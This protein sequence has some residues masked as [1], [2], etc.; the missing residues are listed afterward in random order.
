M[1]SGMSR[2]GSLVFV[3]LAGCT[4]CSK[5]T[6]S[7]PEGS[8]PA[9]NKPDDSAFKDSAKPTEMKDQKFEERLR[10]HS[11]EGT[12]TVDAPADAKAGSETTATITVKPKTGYHVNTEYPIKLALDPPANVTLA[13]KELNAGGRTKDKGDAEALD[14]Q[15]L[16]LAVKLT[17]AQA[18]SYTINGSFKFAVCDKDQCLQKKEPITITVAAK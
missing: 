8:K 14:E 11:E 7:N 16:V 17:A 15:Q 18:G 4:G 12:L 1:F 3:L 6:A 10:L 13:K 5:S 9:A 2:V